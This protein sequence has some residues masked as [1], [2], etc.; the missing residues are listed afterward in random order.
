MYILPHPENVA[1][2]VETLFTPTPVGFFPRSFLKGMR[3]FTYNLQINRGGFNAFMAKP[4]IRFP[5][6]LVK[7]QNQLRFHLVFERLLEVFVGTSSG[8]FFS[9]PESSWRIS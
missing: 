6:A 7:L 3:L 4:L 9:S 2:N 1:T 8:R 5:H